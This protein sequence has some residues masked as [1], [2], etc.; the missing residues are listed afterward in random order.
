MQEP[1]SRLSASRAE[2]KAIEPSP[3]ILEVITEIDTAESDQEINDI[4]QPN[5]F[6]REGK[7]R[8]SRS[9]FKQVRRLYG[10]LEGQDREF[11][12]L[13]YGFD[14]HR[15]HTYHEIKSKMNITMA[16]IRE[17]RRG[18]LG[19][20]KQPETEALSG[21]AF[22][23][24]RMEGILPS[25]GRREQQIAMLH[26]GDGSGQHKPLSVQE[27]NERLFNNTPVGE[28]RIRGFL[29]ALFNEIYAFEDRQE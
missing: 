8:F 1:R 9:E 23:R 3:E 26:Y 7:C 20:K 17:I 15:S 14:T 16:E 22:F 28:L 24:K 11:A 6:P 4:S 18:L 12:A 29:Q 5:E 19:L 25:L 10:G 27:I 13:R 2:E 21:T